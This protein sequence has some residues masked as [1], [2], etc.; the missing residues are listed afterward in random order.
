[1]KSRERHYNSS[2]RRNG[3]LG[4]GVLGL[5]MLVSHQNCAPSD[6]ISAISAQAGVGAESGNPVSIIDESK[7]IAG[8]RF[9]YG[10]IELAGSAGVVHLQG[11]CPKNQDGAILAWRLI[12]LRDDGGQGAIVEQGR[13]TCSEEHFVIQASASALVCDRHYRAHAQLGFGQAGEVILHKPCQR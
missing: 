3:I 1:M 12:E 2:G 13:A 4:L 6:R 8:L 5:M 7:S 10:E 9:P 11:D